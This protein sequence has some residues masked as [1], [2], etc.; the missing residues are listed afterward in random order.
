MN[1]VVA[2][3]IVATF[4][5]ICF[6]FSVFGFVI[7]PKLNYA[8]CCIPKKACHN[9]GDLEHALNVAFD[10]SQW[11]D[12][13]IALRDS[14]TSLCVLFGAS[15]M[16]SAFSTGD[17]GC[18][19]DMALSKALYPQRPSYP[20]QANINTS[21]WPWNRT[22]VPNDS[23]DCTRKTSNA[24]N[25]ASS[26]FLFLGAI[27]CAGLIFG[28]IGRVDIL[29]VGGCIALFIC[30]VVTLAT[31]AV[32]LSRGHVHFSTADTDH[33]ESSS[34]ADLSATPDCPER[35]QRSE[36]ISVQYLL[37]YPKDDSAPNPSKPNFYSFNKLRWLLGVHIA[38]G[39]ASVVAAPV[40]I[41]LWRGLT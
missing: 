29:S 19:T 28:T 30:G 13:A 15:P 41:L 24:N 3:A 35:Y 9:L 20:N 34:P 26:V 39:A 40:Y 27:S 21:S 31:A 17:F 36:L 23:S 33:A 6:T 10:G 5:V 22:C 7:Y 16:L 32:V 38:L 37:P 8:N 1:I 14:T 11:Y 4:A 12:R 25:V 18:S 2:N